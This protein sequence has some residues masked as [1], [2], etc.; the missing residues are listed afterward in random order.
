ME[1]AELKEIQTALPYFL[2]H[3]TV[4]SSYDSEADVLYLHFKKTNIADNSEM[5]KDEIM[6][7]YEN[8]EIIGITI[9]NASKKIKTVFSKGE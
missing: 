8:N 2:K 1:T 4:W 5:T 3:K 6:I 9:L 7:R